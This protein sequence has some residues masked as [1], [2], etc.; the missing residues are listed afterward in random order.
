MNLG[1][2]AHVDA[3]KTSLTERLLFD[4][5]AIGSL[6]SVDEGTTR[7]DSMTLEQQRGI[8]IRAAVTAVRFG[9]REVN[10]IDTPGHSDFIAEVERALGVLDSAVL[11]VSA[12][13][14]VQ[15]QTVVLWRAL[16][17]IG[18]PTAVFV[19]KVDRGGADPD[20]V[21]EQIR[22]RLSGN[23]VALNRCSVPG[24]RE[25]VCTRSSF[26][27]D[28]IVETVAQRDTALLEAWAE[29]GPVAERDVIEAMR[30]GTAAG[31]LFPVVV[32]SAVTGTGAE[33]LEWVL[34]EIFAPV[35]VEGERPSGTVFAVDY[36]GGARRTWVRMWS[37][38]LR[39]RDRVSVAAREPAR[40]THLIVPTP[41]G[42]RERGEV[43]AGDIVAIR[44]PRAR[45][46][47]SF[48]DPPI[49]RIP[50][51][52][53]PTLQTTVTPVDPARRGVL[54]AGLS[55]LAE[56]DPL[57]GL[58]LDEDNGDAT[59][60][61]HGE[62]HREVIAALLAQRYGVAV[63]FEQTQVA[64]VETVD[65][66]GSAIELM[67]HG[68]NP[69]L[70]TIG[71]EIEAAPEIDGVEFTA[72]VERGNLPAAFVAAC[73]EGVRATLAQGLWGWP[74]GGCRVRM[75]A[76]GYAP[77]QSHAHQKFNKAMS[78]VGADFRRLA[79]VVTM[80]CL[81]QAGTTVREPVERFDLDVPAWALGAA[82]N[83]LGRHA[84][85]LSETVEVGRYRRLRGFL[86]SSRLSSLLRTLPNIT[87]G[88][89][90][91]TSSVDHYQP[92]TGG[93]PP[94]RRRT[95]VDP[96]DRVA[97]FRDMPR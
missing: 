8:T 22:D 12:V 68:D 46:G 11:V 49:R 57:I 83:A 3:G 73:A 96:R 48:G 76:S 77:R 25:S 63:E 54:F 66:R 91:L 43:N 64:C 80:A 26:V 23:V 37:G 81:R 95:G 50:R 59:V 6:G 71:L 14:G 20:R 86:P 27:E 32:G 62:V 60:R 29:D 21:I 78:S 44:G 35:R 88:E 38:T 31:A 52:S 33:T 17:R 45:I 18:V 41:D 97:W 19:N 56:E 67:G 51:L 75:T 30:R 85:V 72:G 93:T 28:E 82:M 1:V 65:G 39:V 89:G 69:Y 2:V 92:V 40:L 90:V 79:P 58:D 9:E 36:N 53:P 55:E 70:A 7:T 4:S 34:T 61:I 13:E 47:D 94:R 74:V 84:A 10:I 24:S 5:G 87:E 15:P 42:E 16:R